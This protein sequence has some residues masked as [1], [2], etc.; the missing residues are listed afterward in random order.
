MES[1][2]S[3]LIAFLGLSFL[4]FIHELGHY[5]V[6]IKTGMKVETFSI[7]FGKP[8][9]SFKIR[10]VKWQIGALPFG[11][12]VKIAGMEK[13]GKLEPHQI[14]GG[15]YG[16]APWKR[17]LVALAGPL[18]NI[19][20][21]VGIF[22]LLFVL[23]GRVQN[24]SQHTK[25][26][27]FVD[28]K[29]LL[30]E[31]KV[32]AGDQLVKIDGKPIQ[33]F[34]DIL[35]SSV[36]KKNKIDV[37]GVHLDYF[38]R[39]KIPFSLSVE[40]YYDSSFASKELKTIGIKA[41]AQY[42]LYRPDL[43]NPIFSDQFEEAGM[44]PFDRI[45][46]VNGELI[47]SIQQLSEVI[48]QNKVL[49]SVKRGDK[50]F[51]TRVPRL[52]I[53]DLRLSTV[54]KED[55]V[56]KKHALNL[57][58]PINQLEFI[59]YEVDTKGFVLGAVPFIDENAEQ[60]T[61]YSRKANQYDSLLKRGD[62]IIAI[63]GEEI[64]NALD[65]FAKVQLKKVVAIVQRDGFDKPIQESDQD[66]VFFNEIDSKQL[67]QLISQIGFTKKQGNSGNYILLKPI[68]PIL[69][70]NL[71]GNAQEQANV[72]KQLE[73][74]LQQLAD[75]KFLDERQQVA[76]E[77]YDL[78]HKLYLGISLQDRSVI[79]NPSPV[80]QIVDV[81]NQTKTTFSYLLSGQ[82]SPKWLAGPVG[83]IQ[84]VQQSAAL[85][86]K[87]VL[88]WMA[89]I[90]FNLAIFNLLPIPILDGGHIVMAVIEQITDK[91]IPTKVKEMIMIPFMVLLVGL[92]LYVTFH[93]ISRIVLRFFH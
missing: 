89:L 24:F 55:L 54:Q 9:F 29:S 30:N 10:D 38:K 39:T 21:S 47:F 18:V 11:G 78:N 88:Y 60:S 87:E 42:L 14:P 69:K 51:L 34:Q 4:I 8:I 37:Q 91:P 53:A 50:T 1:I 81:L 44:K 49:V 48:N 90:S 63:N 23:G 7:G 58:Q 66:L 17:I 31:K 43:T 93:D 25:L 64:Q 74:K 13:S 84:L 75:P 2:L 72:Q 62:R 20:F 92:I 56:D 45:L 26:I 61:V 65:L 41:P 46:W 73:M 70:R 32:K 76:K 77:L 71:I 59:P 57:A 6:A 40:P 3:F 85:G 80:Q 82:I 33:S 27:G 52:S 68:Q 86:F 79:Y 16:S 19:I 36:L 12:F 67:S 28:Q 35:F 15:F 22:S 5:I 83:M